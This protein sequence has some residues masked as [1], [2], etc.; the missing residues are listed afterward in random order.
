MILSTNLLH[1]LFH[2]KET[3]LNFLE[4]D[5]LCLIKL[6]ASSNISRAT[7]GIA[8]VLRL[9]SQNMQNGETFGV[10]FVANNLFWPLHGYRFTLENL[11][12][13]PNAY[14]ILLKVVRSSDYKFSSSE[15]HWSIRATEVGL[16]AMQNRSKF[17]NKCLKKFTVL[18]LSGAY[19]S[20]MQCSDKFSCKLTIWSFNNWYSTAIIYWTN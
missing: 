2:L 20:E 12:I 15:V 7:N 6:A 17:Q 14:G 19:L 18:D 4:G 11:D 5:K 10:R 3:F 1:I 13:L 9:V 16:T 8:V